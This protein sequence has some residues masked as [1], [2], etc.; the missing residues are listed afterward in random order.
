MKESCKICG[1]T[2]GNKTHQA[3]E[4]LLGTR[5]AFTYLEC[6]NCG[7]V[8]LLDIPIDMGR[9]YP[10][11][12]YSFQEQG[13]LKT[14]LRRQWSA[15]SYGRKNLW[16]WLLSKQMG[17]NIAIQAVRRARVADSAR[18]L[19]VGCG[20]GH[21]LLDLAYLGFTSLTGVDPFI[22]ADLTYGNGVKVFKRG[23]AEMS[24]QF[25]LI[26]FHYS[27]EHMDKPA[28]VM[29]HVWRLLGPSGKA[30]IRI[31]LASS[32][33]WRHYAVH[34]FNLDAP[35]HFYIHTYRSM[36]LLAERA[37]LQLTET[38]QEGGGATFWYSE[39]YKNDISHNTPEFL[40]NRPLKRILLSKR[41][42]SW[43][44]QAED[45]RRKGDSD[46]V[47]FYLERKK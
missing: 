9:Y 12:Y 10:S 30:I 5:D 42:R 26:T 34:W 27:Y 35:R 28:E 4:M 25:E 40:G 19:D 3:R 16:G 6:S 24:G 2:Q 7:C 15:Y 41:I 13:R 33:A 43:N 23:L 44:A 36:D 45:L 20:S 1:N 21:L 17:P 29:K 32:Y 46:L 37:G 14:Y 8:Q 11:N 38:V 47:A 22:A 31:P 18:I 39:D